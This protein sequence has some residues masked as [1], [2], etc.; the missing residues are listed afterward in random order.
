MV[1][2]Y[3]IIRCREE[4]DKLKEKGRGM[5]QFLCFFGEFCFKL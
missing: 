1:W 5:F 2:G 3:Y 4:I